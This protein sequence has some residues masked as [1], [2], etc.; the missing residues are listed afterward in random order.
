MD[1]N[2]LDWVLA[3]AQE[4]RTLTEWESKFIDDLTDR[5]ERQGDRLVITERQE[6]VLE[7][8]SEKD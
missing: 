5:R 7:R 3:K 6:E 4:A 2:R 8:I 1:M